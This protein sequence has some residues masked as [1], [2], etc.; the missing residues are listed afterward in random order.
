MNADLLPAF[1]WRDDPRYRDETELATQAGMEALCQKIG[2]ILTA[3]ETLEVQSIDKLP[4]KIARANGFAQCP[5]VSCGNKIYL[6]HTCIAELAGIGLA[7]RLR[8]TIGVFLHELGHVDMTPALENAIFQKMRRESNNWKNQERDKYFNVLEDQR[9]ELLEGTKYPRARDYYRLVIIAMLRQALKRDGQLTALAWVLNYG[10]RHLLPQAFMRQLEGLAL[11]ALGLEKVSRIKAMITRYQHLSGRGD[12]S[13]TEMYTLATELSQILGSP[14]SLNAPCH[15]SRASKPKI[16]LKDE[17]ELLD[18]ANAALAKLDANREKQ[19]G[20]QDASHSGDGALGGPDKPDMESL[21]GLEQSIIDKLQHD[22][23]LKMDAL[24]EHIG[25]GL[26][27]QSKDRDGGTDWAESEAEISSARRMAAYFRNVA[28]DL[29]L[30]D[31][32]NLKRGRLDVRRLSS[33]LASNSNR[34]FRHRQPDISRN[35]SMAVHIAFDGSGSMGGFCKVRRLAFST[36]EPKDYISS[37][38]HARSAAYIISRAAELGGH[39]SRV[40][41]FASWTCQVKGWNEKVFSAGRVGGIGSGTDPTDGFRRAVRDFDAICNEKQIK[42][43]VYI[44]ITDGQ[45]YDPAAKKIL[46]ILKKQG[47]YI[48]I[49]GIGFRPANLDNFEVIETKADE[50]EETMRTILKELSFK[51]SRE[52]KRSMR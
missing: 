27:E 25:A 51:I 1:D 11:A 3:S 24:R 33:A 29:K 23:D 13:L 14:Q 7:Q 18:K 41:A 8:I 39:F 19:E 35:A 16:N 28:Q 45:F 40:T 30:E 6:N 15:Q 36:G 37:G 42:N 21:D 48:Y 4:S 2:R 12:S 32:R 31:H 34:I 46:E 17:R 49:L 50:L 22:L 9:E 47:T 5:G 44:I 38:Y 43:T 20:P 10:R 26:D 52:V